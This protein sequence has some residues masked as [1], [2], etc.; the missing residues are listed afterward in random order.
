MFSTFI[1]QNKT[2]A[3]CQDPDACFPAVLP[4]LNPFTRSAEAGRKRRLLLGSEGTACLPAFNS[5]AD[6]DWHWE[7]SGLVPGNGAL[8]LIPQAK[9][10]V[11]LGVWAGTQFLYPY[12]HHDSSEPS[13]W[14]WPRAASLSVEGPGL[15]PWAMSPLLRS[16][17]LARREGQGRL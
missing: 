9:G 13:A 3:T 5:G 4:S 6:G 7:G 10:Q 11:R 15:W 14:G 12:Q 1:F 8:G 17:F 16:K 2:C